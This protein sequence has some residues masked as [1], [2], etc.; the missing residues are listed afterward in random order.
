[1]LGLNDSVAEAVRNLTLPQLV[2]LAETNQCILKVRSDAMGMA[3]LSFSKSVM[4][5]TKMPEDP[6]FAGMQ[7]RKAI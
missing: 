7:K 2:S 6:F 3:K 5:E 1:M 4:G